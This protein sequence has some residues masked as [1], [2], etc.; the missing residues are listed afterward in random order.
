MKAFILDRY[1]GPDCVRAGEMP[2]PDVGDNDVLVRI[3]AAGVNPLDS[4]IRNGEFKQILP[5]RLPLII[6]KG[7]APAW[8][9]ATA[10][11]L[12]HDRRAFARLQVVRELL[13]G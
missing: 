2:E 1:G 5:Y 12:A 13:G 11:R 10:G 8:I 6:G 9:R 7:H 3:H 4:K